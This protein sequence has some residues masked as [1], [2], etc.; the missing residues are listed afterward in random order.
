[1]SLSLSKPGDPAEAARATPAAQA[2]PALRVGTWTLLHVLWKSFFFLAAANYQRMQNVGFAYAMLPA[3]RRLYQGP[4]LRRALERH[5]EFFNSHP[6]LACALLG[7]SVRI[8]EDI[9][10]GRSGPDRVRAFKRTMMGPVAALGDGFFWT[11]LKPFAAGWAIFALMSGVYWAPIA[12]LVV[13]NACH[14]GVRIYGI[15]H[16]YR[17]AERVGIDLHRLQL[18]RLSDWAHILMGLALGGIAAGYVERAEAAHVLGHHGLEVLLLA[19]LIVITL[20]S[21]RRHL[22]MLIMLNVLALGTVLFVVGLQ[23]LFPILGE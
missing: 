3:L 11:S 6:Y 7:A 20:L 18:V 17:A 1:M 15:F 19:I 21:L 5:L 14:I 23:A 13:Y 16:G 4:E 12:F 2:T 9:A 8:E 22:P 10:A